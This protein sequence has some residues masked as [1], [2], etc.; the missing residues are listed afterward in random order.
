M[1][2]GFKFGGVD[3]GEQV[4][5]PV[6]ERTVHPGLAG[7]AANADRGA[8]LRGVF[9]RVGD[10]LAPAVGASLAPAA[11]GGDHPAPHGRTSG[12]GWRIFGRP[13]MTV[14]PR[15]TT[16]TASSIWVRSSGV[17]SPGDQASD[18]ADLLFGR[19]GFRAG[20]VIGLEGGHQ[21][22]AAAEPVSKCVLR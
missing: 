3:Q 17:R 11:H 1:A 14:R 16:V 4:T 2:G 7:D 22:I 19:H 15:R 21:P 6:E 5:V 12:S 18:P 10:A 8:V 9:D 20:P 13:S